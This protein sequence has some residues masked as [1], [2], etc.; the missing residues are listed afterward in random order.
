M[1]TKNKHKIIIEAKIKRKN[2]E[3]EER[4]L[5]QI[6]SPFSLQKFKNILSKWSDK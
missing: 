3:I 2:G 4:T 5:T 1:E 6:E